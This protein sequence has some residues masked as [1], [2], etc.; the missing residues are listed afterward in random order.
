VKKPPYFPF[1]VSDWNG[2]KAVLLMDSQQHGYYI[3]LMTRAWDEIPIGTLPNDPDLL[4]R[5]ARA[6]NRTEFEKRSAL[7]LEQF[8]P[9]RNGRRLQHPRLVKEASKYAETCRQNARAGKEGAKS[10][11]KKDL[12]D[13][14]RHHAAMPDA[15]AKNGQSELEPE[16]ELKPQTPSRNTTFSQDHSTVVVQKGGKKNGWIDRDQERQRGTATNLDR[17]FPE[18]EAVAGCSARHSNETAH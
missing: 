12:P 18:S 13:G 11:W 14:A 1:Y 15:M 4:W 6:K 8:K 16:S 9:T 17:V 10:R 2:S 5:L 3:N 7:V